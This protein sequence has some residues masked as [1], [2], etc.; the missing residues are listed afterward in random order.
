ME[1]TKL[2]KSLFKSPDVCNTTI[3]GKVHSLLSSLNVYQVQLLVLPNPEV[4]GCAFFN[5][6]DIFRKYPGD[7]RG[8]GIPNANCVILQYDIV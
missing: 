6:T 5:D 7:S 8:G 1:L 2:E 3:S 4:F